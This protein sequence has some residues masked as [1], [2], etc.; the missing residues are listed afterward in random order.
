MPGDFFKPDS[1]D[2]GAL[3]QFYDSQYLKFLFFVPLLLVLGW[4]SARLWRGRLQKLGYEPVVTAKLIPAYRRA[5]VGIRIFLLMLVF[6]CLILAL[7]R[8]QWGES[9]KKVERKGVDKRP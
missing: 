4:L 5:E 1:S 7:A 8:P 6:F 2:D 9:S 3:M